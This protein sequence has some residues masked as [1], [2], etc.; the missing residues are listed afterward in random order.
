MS[1]EKFGSENTPEPT[2]AQTGE[3]V[4]SSVAP[5]PPPPAPSDAEPAT[6]AIPAG[7]AEPATQRLAVGTA[8]PDAGE[9][10]AVV[11]AATATPA[12]TA[13]EANPLD[14]FE[15]DRR[16]SGRGTKVFLGTMGVL[17]LL[18][19][20]YAGAAWYVQDKI[21]TG[22]TVE[23]VDIGG[24]TA[25]DAKAKL[26]E[27]LGEPLSQPIPLRAGELSAELDPTTSGLSLDVPATVDSVT[28]FSLD[29]HRLL[30]HLTGGD[31]I[32]PVSAVDETKLRAALDGIAPQL[33][34]EPVNGAIDLST[35]SAVIT[36]PIEGVAVN[37]DESIGLVSEA[38][39]D[40]EP[41]ELAVET[42]EPAISAADI[43]TA[44]RDIV[45][46]M[47]SA[48]VTLTVGETTHE[49][50]TAD[51]AAASSIVATDAGTLEL[52]VNGEPLT[53]KILEE[54][55]EIGDVGVDA[56]FIFQD[57]VPT[58][59]P[60]EPGLGI[61]A[62]AVATAV[63]DAALT[64][65]RS[66]S[67][68]IVETEPE[69]TTEDAEKLGIV[70]VVSEFSTPLTD[71][72]VRT[73]NLIAGT[74]KLDGWLVLPGERFSLLEVLAPI[75]AANGY[76]S[77]GVVNG[78]VATEAVGGGL[79]QLSTTTFNAAFFAGM[80][81]FDHKPHTR[82][83]TRYPQGREA[84]LWDPEIDMAFTNDT[85]YGLL[86][87]SWVADG[88]VWVR[89][90]S[91]KYYTVESST[92]EPYNYTSS[93]TIYNTDPQCTPESG[94]REGFTVDVYRARYLD[95]ALHD[96]WSYS[97]TYTAWPRVICGPAP[98]DG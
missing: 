67:V 23:G 75:S 8:Q 42:T 22:T 34:V 95:G 19:G 74:A 11:P 66:S 79:S 30:P 10:T 40:Q 55:P 60:S 1:E 89:A 18:G 26:E 5:P 90:W 98:S 92:S 63:R 94:G 93:E 6:Q 4:E 65:T 81:D 37:V 9:P 70:E 76:V 58:I 62:E 16:R 53:E 84:T 21:P 20:A 14:G 46:P 73:S 69:V 41:I 25:D 38:W 86:F 82:W 59:V 27:H 72:S 88:Q 96:D 85:P 17:A 3:P 29:P 36:E 13:S 28:G 71:D 80:A 47:L 77:S 15:P 97:W 33:A 24:L 49:I 43:D 87:Q 48:P 83:F 91:T 45:G 7:D 12:A 39:M 57:G 52:Q 56:S 32:P 44:M 68:Q 61:D 64:D 50:A 78:G 35:G 31:E 2:E 54:S 51:I